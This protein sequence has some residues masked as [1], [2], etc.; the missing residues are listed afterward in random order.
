MY[1]YP[2]SSTH[3]QCVKTWLS[4]KDKPLF[5][6]GQPGTGKSTLSKQ[7]LIDYHI[8]HVNSDHLKY[9]GKLCD[10]IKSSLFK[11]NILMMCSTNHYKALLIDD[12]QL[13]VKYDKSNIKNIYDYVKTHT[14]TNIPIVITC[15]QVSNKYILLLQKISYNITLNSTKQLYKSIIKKELKGTKGNK[16]M[17]TTQ[18]NQFINTSDNLHTLK[19]NLFGF[20]HSKDKVYSINDV[21]PI[22]FNSTKSINELCSLCS[23]EY[24]TIALNILENIPYILRGNYVDIMY[25]IYDSVC[26]GDYI[27]SKCLDKCLDPYIIILY[28]C[29]CPIIYLYGNI[30]I[31]KQYKFTY[32]SYIGKSL[33]QIHNQ[34]LTCSSPIDY[35]YILSLIYKLTLLTT[36]DHTIN[37]LI[38]DIDFNTK[39]LEKQ[40]KVF[41]YYYNKQLTR[42]HVSKLLKTVQK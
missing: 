24:N 13:F 10:Y 3:K 5:I 42:K 1:K 25:R 19:I 38:K 37:K 33:I 23:S 22:I 18:M 12:L 17:D 6:M 31:R 7:L 32:N 35:L 21:L 4:K 16:S 36:P 9:S 29:V 11:K 15:G 20:K 41:N 40:I 8:I 28:M 27:E 34:N 14:N 2:L 39:I 26:I 30:G